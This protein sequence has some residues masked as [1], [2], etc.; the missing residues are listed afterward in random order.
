MPLVADPLAPGEATLPLGD[1]FHFACVGRARGQALRAQLELDSLDAKGAPIHV[2]VAPHIRAI[3]ASFFLGLLGPSV[4]GAESLDAFNARI[5]V[6]A[7]PALAAA[8][9]GYA[10][11]AWALSTQRAGKADA[12]LPTW[13]AEP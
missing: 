9:R 3:S 12:P 6:T 13:A 1:G 5:R 11:M 2:V 7:G 8:L 4:Q 10:S